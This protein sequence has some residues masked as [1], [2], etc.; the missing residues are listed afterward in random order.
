MGGTGRI[1]RP[2][3]A[4]LEEIFPCYAPDQRGHGGS[5][6]VP[7]GEPSEFH[8]LDYA[9][10]LLEFLDREGLGSVR[11]IGHS[12]G[13]R[14]ALA[15][16]SVAP[17]RIES[18]LAIDIGISSAWGGGIGKPLADFLNALPETFPDRARMREHLF[19]RCPDPAI[20]QYL[21]AVALQSEG[22]L[23]FPFD[24]A[25]LVRTIEQADQAPVGEWLRNALQAGIPC[26]F[27]RGAESKVWLKPDFEEQRIRFAHP[28]LSF[29]EWEGCGHGLPFEQRSKF[30]SRIRELY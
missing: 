27:L 16:C 19:A 11:L 30:V 2:I 12:M 24:H 13:V 21:S 28:L 25:A 8:A 17:E 22:G 20:A 14:S 7:A 10:D 15:L 23:S 5:R 18:L 6:P 9:R 3:A 29:E 4:N 1:W 26:L